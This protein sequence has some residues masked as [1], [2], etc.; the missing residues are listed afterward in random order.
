MFFN[1][2]VSTGPV[3]NNSVPTDVPEVAC[4]LNGVEYKLGE[5]FPSADGCNTCVCQS[6]DVIACT[7][8]ACNTTS[9]L[10]TQSTTVA[11]TAT[12][13]GT[14]NPSPTKSVLPTLGR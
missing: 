8:R 11:P 7:E 5:S 2:P 13:S 4:E 14:Q 10:N 9:T 3:D 1:K 6:P 12:K